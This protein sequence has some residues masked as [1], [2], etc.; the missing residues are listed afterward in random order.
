MIDITQTII[1]SM[2]N[3]RKLAENGSWED[4]KRAREEAIDYYQGD[5]LKHLKKHMAGI[6][7]F[8]GDE[9]LWGFSNITK[10]II[11]G[12]S[13][14]YINAPVRKRNKKIDD[15]YN[16]WTRD[17]DRTMLNA[18]R[19]TSLID[20]VGIKVEWDAIKKKYRYRFLKYDVYYELDYTGEDVKAV[21]YRVDAQG[22][23]TSKHET[24]LEYWNNEIRTIC[25]GDGKCSKDLE[26]Y[27][28]KDENNPYGLIPIY[29]PF[30]SNN[31]AYDLINANK[32]INAKMTE[33]NELVKY[34]SFGIPYVTGYK[35]TADKIKLDYKYMMKLSDPGAKVGMLELTTQL[36]QVIDSIKFDIA[37]ICENWGV[38][39]NWSIQG[40]VSGFSLMVQNV[41]LY[42]N[43]RVDNSMRRIWEE[44]IYDIEMAVINLKTIPDFTIDFS[45]YVL[46]VNKDDQ[47]AWE[48]HQLKNG[49]TNPVELIRK[50]NPDLSEKQAKEQ[51]EENLEMM[52]SNTDATTPEVASTNPFDKL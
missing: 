38:S 26:A 34:R 36:N 4:L 33:F 7:D 49:L 37:T 9:I 32:N 18:D 30:K 43:I 14:S 51:Y 11:N 27:G 45:E 17:K 6:M 47:I 41:E 3:S 35:G 23:D 40:D 15:Q 50:N 13:L 2:E 52:K 12:T 8:R 21:W 19:Y 1:N 24:M 10:K 31:I 25:D 28:I 39:F 5:Q 46:P 16:K 29:I 20:Y 22:K 42:D 44:A 48:N